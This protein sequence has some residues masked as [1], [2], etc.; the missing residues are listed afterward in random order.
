MPSHS[1]A[2]FPSR[3]RNPLCIS[4][5]CRHCPPPSPSPATLPQLRPNSGVAPMRI[6]LHNLCLILLYK[7]LL[8]VPQRLKSAMRTTA[9]F[10]REQPPTGR[11][12]GAFAAVHSPHERRSHR[13]RPQPVGFRVPNELG[14]VQIELQAPFQPLADVG[15]QT[16]AHRPIHHFRI[17]HRR[18]ARPDAVQEIPHVVQRPLRPAP[19]F[20]QNPV[21]FAQQC[22]R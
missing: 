6:G 13:P 1:F 14:P 21:V 11:L 5:L 9:P 3:V 12:L 19:V 15:R 17:R 7:A 8:V 22:R 2:F 20:R 16:N 10:S 4:I 18:P